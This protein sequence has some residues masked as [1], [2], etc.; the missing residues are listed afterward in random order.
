MKEKST[1]PSFWTESR[2]QRLIM[3]YNRFK[4]SDRCFEKVAQKLKTTKNA[5]YKKIG[6]LGHLDADWSKNYEKVEY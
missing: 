2:E 1:T 5:V 3:W 6:R 4:D